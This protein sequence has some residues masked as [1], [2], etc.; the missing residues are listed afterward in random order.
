MHIAMCEAARLARDAGL[1][2]G[3]NV[4]GKFTL[5]GPDSV[6]VPMNENSMRAYVSKAQMFCLGRGHNNPMQD[7]V[8]YV[9][10]AQRRS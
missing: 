7:G 8:L 1:P 3:L 10:K 9:R 4:L 6:L 5:D 2:M